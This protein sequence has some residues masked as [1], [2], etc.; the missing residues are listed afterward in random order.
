MKMRKPWLMRKPT[1]KVDTERRECTVHIAAV[2]YRPVC[3]VSSVFQAQ[4]DSNTRATAD[5]A[6]A[7]VACCPANGYTLN[8]FF[9]AV[10]LLPRHMSHGQGASAQAPRKLYIYSI[11]TCLRHTDRSRD[12]AL[13]LGRVLCRAF[14]VSTFIVSDV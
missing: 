8:L 11:S 7:C 12:H 1:S 3:C 14:A 9:G 2:A 4:S 10:S 5:Q 13:G 6:H